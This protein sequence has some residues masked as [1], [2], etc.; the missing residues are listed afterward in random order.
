MTKEDFSFIE[1]H[2]CFGESILN[3][4]STNH[5]KGFFIQGYIA[6]FYFINPVLFSLILENMTWIYMSVIL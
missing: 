4:K 6:T 2:I 3:C 1:A 5:R